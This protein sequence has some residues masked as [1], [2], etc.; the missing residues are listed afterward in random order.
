MMNKC[1]RGSFSHRN[2]IISEVGIICGVNIKPLKVKYE[3]N[4]NIKFRYG[5]IIGDKNS[6]YNVATWALF[7]H[8]RME[9]GDQYDAIFKIDKSACNGI[10]M[11]SVKFPYDK[12][13]T[14]PQI[15][16]LC[17]VEEWV[18][19]T[20]K[21][22]EVLTSRDDKG[23]VVSLKI[24]ALGHGVIPRTSTHFEITKN[25]FEPQVYIERKN[26]GV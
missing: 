6:Q 15:L 14:I 10:V 16:R 5:K 19:L 2:K 21:K 1:K 4:K 20:G 11:R 24:R 23:E 12:F 18:E 8:I 13:F 25:K 26:K 22:M 3:L 7:I 17:G 9:S